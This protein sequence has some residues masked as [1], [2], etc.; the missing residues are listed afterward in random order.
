MVGAEQHARA[1]EREAQ[2]V[3]AMAW[4]VDRGQAPVPALDGGAVR[5]RHV[6]A[7]GMV[8]AL[9]ALVRRRHVRAEAVG[10]RAGCGLQRR[11]AG[12]VVAMG[13]GDE[14]MGDPLA[15]RGA[16]DRREVVGILGPRVEH[17]DGAAGADDPG[18]GAAP[19]EG[20]GIA[21]EE[22][23]DAG[24]DLGRDADGQRVVLEEG[25]AHW[26]LRCRD[27]TSSRC[28]MYNPDKTMRAAPASVLQPGASE[29]TTQPIATDH[30]IEV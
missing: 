13:V 12:R 5:E 16:Q 1:L 26:F 7:E 8:A 30:R 4:G 17:G 24:G 20:A 3:R 22:A 15:F 14:D 27:R 11:D 21:A 28:R 2:V 23:A 18:V 9:P 6:G 29:K 25:D 19:G 10:T